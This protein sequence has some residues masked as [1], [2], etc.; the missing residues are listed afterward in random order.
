MGS[1][2]ASRSG[3]RIGREGVNSLTWQLTNPIAMRLKATLFSIALLF[4]SLWASAQAGSIQQQ[5]EKLAHQLIIT[6][7]H[8]DLPYRLKVQNFRLEREYLGIPIET[9]KGDFDYV[10]AKKGGLDAPF[11]SIYLPASYQ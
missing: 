8:V 1:K 2:A 4:S 5:A 3:G 11:M 9:E 6:D 7:G 10:R